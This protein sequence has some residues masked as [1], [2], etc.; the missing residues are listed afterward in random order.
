MA[1]STTSQ[2][3]APSTAPPKPKPSQPPV[4]ILPTQFAR[5]YALAHPALLL[6]LI[7]YRFSSV[8]E[9][10]V[11]ELLGDIPYL[12][13]LQAVYVMGCLPP[14]GSEKETSSDTSETKTVKKSASMSALR[15]RGKAAGGSSWSTGLVLVAWK[16]TPALL[17]LT[18]TTLLSTPVLAILLILFGAPF[19]THHALTFLCAAHMALLT[20][21][22]LIYTHGVDGNVWSEIWGAARPLDAVWGGALGTCIGAWL[23]AVPI[24]LDWDRPWQAYPITILTGAYIGYAAGMLLCRVQGLYGKKVQFAPGPEELAAAR[25]EAKKLE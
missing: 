6:S 15:R 8:V 12:V 21:F 13:G 7:V 18:L 20:S 22:P 25:G 2:T 9:N 17:S 19:T 1:S 16:L 5:V 11:A 4:Q 24:P 10:P 3:P 14:A 23:G